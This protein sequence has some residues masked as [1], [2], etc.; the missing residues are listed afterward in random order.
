[1]LLLMLMLL[2]LLLLLQC[3]HL[4]HCLHWSMVLGRLLCRTRD[5]LGE[6]LGTHHGFN[7]I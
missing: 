2:L 4:R 6:S 5:L 3:G 7:L 1:M